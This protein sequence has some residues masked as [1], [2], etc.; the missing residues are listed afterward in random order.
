VFAGVK[1]K[2][3]ITE[4]FIAH[5]ARLNMFAAHGGWPQPARSFQARDRGEDRANWIFRS[6][7]YYPSS[8]TLQMCGCLG[9]Q[10]SPK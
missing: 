9:T 10:M 3:G 4:G 6:F 8:N 7:K 5:V 1:R 2:A